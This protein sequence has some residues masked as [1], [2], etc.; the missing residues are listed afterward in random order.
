MLP[1]TDIAIMVIWSSASIGSAIVIEHEVTDLV[2]IR[3]YSELFPPASWATIFMVCW[4]FKS[5]WK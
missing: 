1:I 5:C 3:V 2:K 4:P